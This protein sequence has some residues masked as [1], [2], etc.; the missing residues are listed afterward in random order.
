MSTSPSSAIVSD[1]TSDDSGT[2]ERSPGPSS[3]TS[4]TVWMA[5]PPKM[6]PTASDRL[7]L[8][9]QPTMIAT[10]GKFVAR[11]RNTAPPIPSPHPK[12]ASMASVV[13]ARMPPAHQISTPAAMKI[14]MI[15]GVASVL[16]GGCFPGFAPTIPCESRT[17][18]VASGC[19]TRA[20][21]RSP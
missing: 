4:T 13:A 20:S 7:W 6:L 15:T 12:C 19:G 16:T 21:R 9:T 10:S 1:G 17:R 2:F 14:A 8:Y 11:A 18:R 5:I 3:S